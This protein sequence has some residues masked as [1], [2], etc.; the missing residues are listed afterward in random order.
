MGLMNAKSHPGAQTL[1]IYESRIP[2]RRLCKIAHIDG[3]RMLRLNA[4]KHEGR[5]LSLDL[6]LE[7]SNFDRSCRRWRRPSPSADRDRDG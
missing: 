1:T 7:L 4:P 6:R 3:E 5:D 2:R